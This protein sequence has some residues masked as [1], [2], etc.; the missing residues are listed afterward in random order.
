MPIETLDALITI[1]GVDVTAY[2]ER[3][4]RT[5]TLEKPPASVEMTF[6]KSLN[7]SA[8]SPWDALVIKEQGVKTFTGYVSNIIPRRMPRAEVLIQGQDAYKRALDWFVGEEYATTGSSGLTVGY[9]TGLFCDLC[10]L[11]YT[12]LDA[13]GAATPINI[14]IPLGLRSV[15]EILIQMCQIGQW[16]MWVDANGVL[17]FDHIDY[18]TSAD[19]TL[20]EVES[21]EEEFND[22]DTRN[23]VKIWGMWHDRQ[24][25]AG[26]I[27]YQE[28]RIVPG[29]PHTR[30]MLFSAPAIDT[31]AK[32]ITI[33]RAA[34]DQ[35]AKLEHLERVTLIGNPNIRVGQSFQHSHVRLS[36]GSYLNTV[37]DLRAT[38][39]SA[40]YTQD[41]TGGRRAYRYPFWT[42][43][44]TPV[45]YFDDGEVV[46]VLGYLGGFPSFTQASATLNFNNP[47]PSWYNLGGNL[48]GFPRGIS[49]DKINGKNVY[50]LTDDGVWKLDDVSVSGS[51][52]NHLL[53]KNQIINLIVTTPP[54]NTF[55][56]GSD[57]TD[58]TG[59]SIAPR[60][61]GVVAFTCT[62]Y[63]AVA[64]F[65]DQHVGIFLIKTN[66]AGVDW[67]ASGYYWNASTGPGGFPLSGGTSVSS[68]FGE[69]SFSYDK[70]DDSGN[71][72]AILVTSPFNIEMNTSSQSEAY[73]TRE[74]NRLVLWSNGSV[75]VQVDYKPNPVTP[76]TGFVNAASFSRAIALSKDGDGNFALGLSVDGHL[77]SWNW[78]PPTVG[79]PPPVN[80]FWV[81]LG[82]VGAANAIVAMPDN[83]LNFAICGTGFINWTNDGGATWSNKTGG[84]FPVGIVFYDL[85]Y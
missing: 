33:A 23:A 13:A 27:L 63:Q 21:F 19:Y 31:Q 52:W 79:M 84:G 57:I 4:E 77:W 51:T 10:G 16:Q 29:V 12:I 26:Q 25:G 59:L 43:G 65:G 46:V 80:D 30:A 6:S 55:F 14:D 37:T 20:G 78:I 72:V 8:I 83:R 28:Q 66:N 36:G 1:G 48:T 41:L 22:I 40:G 74:E 75:Y 54:F 44:S 56:S 42:S 53:T 38:L 32:A 17:N 49:T 35:W 15:A 69:L 9:Y 71:P 82:P 50:A 73:H 60:I 18:A 70:K 62:I 61:E 68:R 76:N 64:P 11:S 81:D 2:L 47:S 3:L 24:N 34:L 7:W 45:N 67:E 39:S 85:D 5:A 58:V